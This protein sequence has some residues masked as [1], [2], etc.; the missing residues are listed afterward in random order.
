MAP[1]GMWDIAKKRTVDNGGAVHKEGKLVQGIQSQA[2]RTL[3]Q[4]L[5]KGQHRR[6]SRRHVEQELGS[7]RSR[8]HPP[9]EGV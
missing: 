2:R 7:Q 8:V 4:Q 6:R 1:K 9:E 3:S 5:V